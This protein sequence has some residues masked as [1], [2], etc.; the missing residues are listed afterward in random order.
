MVRAMLLG[1]PAPKSLWGYALMYATWLKNRIPNKAIESEG[2]TP[3][4]MVYGV[5]PDL[6]RAKEWGCKVFVNAKGKDKFDARAREGRYLGPS[7]ETSDGFHVYWPETGR[8]R[9]VTV[10]RSVRFLDGSAFEGE[11]EA[12]PGVPTA[13][14]C[15][16]GYTPNPSIHRSEPLK[17]SQNTILI[18]A[19]TS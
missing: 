11:Q 8:D 7:S 14:P 18:V 3:Y 17:H 12:S 6:S 16:E 4:E 15:D 9:R 19:N 1:S 13:T 5:K 2:K 10:E